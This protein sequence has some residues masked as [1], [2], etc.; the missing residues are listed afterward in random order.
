MAARMIVCT[1]PDAR[2]A[3]AVRGAVEGP[4]T[5]D[6]PASILHRHGDCHLFLDPPAAS[7]L[8]SGR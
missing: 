6:L 1:V 4:V 2:N 3:D 8:G 7:K 5:P